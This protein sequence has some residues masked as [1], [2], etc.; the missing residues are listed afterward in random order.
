MKK[1][2][3]VLALFALA[4]NNEEKSAEKEVYKAEVPVIDS[5][6][7]EDSLHIGDSVDVREPIK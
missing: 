3:I 7:V 2:L 5:L 4:C 6:P 1:L